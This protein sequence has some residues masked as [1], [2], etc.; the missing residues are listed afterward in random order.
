M[1]AGIQSTQV[2]RLEPVA[3]DNLS[4]LL[5][6]LEVTL[7]HCWAANRDLTDPFLIRVDDSQF[8]S[9]QWLAY[10]IR[11][12]WL[13]VVDGDR[14]SSFRQAISVGH[15]DSQVVKKLQRTRLRESTTGDQRK[16]LAAEGLV[17]LRKQAAAQTWFWCAAREKTVNGN[18]AIEHPATE[19]RQLVE[20]SSQARFN[21]LQNHRNDAGIGDLE[22]RK[23]FLQV[24][25]PQSPQV[26]D[27][28]ATNKRSD[29]PNHE[30]DGVICRQNA[31]ITHACP[32][33]EPGH[34]RLALL[35]IVAMRQHA[36]LWPTTRSG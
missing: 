28:G 26:H 8:D 22:A 20:A 12:K 7:H 18:E 3:D 6:I 1:P 29:K 14:R 30:I 5:R 2:A 36:S 25:R 21:G 35:E 13:K 34:E 27:G 23:R 16:E 32:E 17:N 24:F 4:R 33:W 9:R 15:G 10:G 31:Q 11:S 19:G